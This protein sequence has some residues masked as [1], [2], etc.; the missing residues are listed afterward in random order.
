MTHTLKESLTVKCI[1][2]KWPKNLQLLSNKLKYI[3]A[4]SSKKDT[5]PAKIFCCTTVYKTFKVV[6]TSY[7]QNNTPSL[8][9]NYYMS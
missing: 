5:S 8:M 9:S 7:I 1:V 2:Q 3:L 4:S 6:V